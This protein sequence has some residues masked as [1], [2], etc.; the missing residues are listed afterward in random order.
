MIQRIRREYGYRYGIFG[1]GVRANYVGVHTYV[2]Q[3][4]Q[5]VYVAKQLLRWRWSKYV[6]LVVNAPVMV[7][8]E[9]GKMYIP[10]ENG[11]EVEATIVK[12]ILKQ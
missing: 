11:K 5:Y 7:A 4:G 9:K 8:I 2:I 12:T 10:T 3:V 1:T 6:D